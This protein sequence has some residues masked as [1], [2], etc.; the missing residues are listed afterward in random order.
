MSLTQI[1]IH[2]EIHIYDSHFFC[3]TTTQST[4][5]DIFDRHACRSLSI[6]NFNFLLFTS[7]LCN[8]AVSHKTIQRLQNCKLKRFLKTD[9]C[10]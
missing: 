3:H 2:N 8:A 5:G 6:V 1:S 9:Y 7:D 10:R 4:H